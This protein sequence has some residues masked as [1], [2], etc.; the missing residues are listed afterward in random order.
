MKIL[1]A[2]DDRR[3]ARLIMRM[4]EN[5]GYR[6]VLCEDGKDGLSSGIHKKTRRIMKKK[7]SMWNIVMNLNCILGL[8]YP[9]KGNKEFRTVKKSPN[10]RLFH[11]VQG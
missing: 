2:E 10:R 11:F 9:F 4:L 8:I 7:R 1:L 6:L 5:E 3:L